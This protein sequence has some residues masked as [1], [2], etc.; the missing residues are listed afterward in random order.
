VD[1]LAAGLDDLGV[2][3]LKR[4]QSPANHLVGAAL[5]KPAEHR[6][7]RGRAAGL[8]RVEGATAG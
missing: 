3:D 6:A 2:G 7:R 8:E 1:R 5:Q 4:D